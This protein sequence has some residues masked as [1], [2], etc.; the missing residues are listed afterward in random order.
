MRNF[1]I[2]IAALFSTS[3][4]AN[5]VSV[6]VDFDKSGITPVILEGARHKEG[7]VP[8]TLDDKVRIASVTKLY[9]ALGVMRLVEQGKLDLDRDVSDYLGWPLRNPAFPDK[10]ISLRLLLSHQS[11]VSDAADYL[12]PV[13]QTI[14]GKMADPKAWD[15][16][17]APGS[18]WFHYTN[19]NFP[20]VASVMERATGERFD[21]LMDRIVMKPLKLTACFNW[22]M[23]TDKDAAMAVT[24]Y[25]STGEV[26][27]DEL[28]GKIPSCPGVASADGRCDLS[29][30][31]LGWNGAIFSPQGGLRVS[32]KD[33]AKTGQMML[34]R[35][36]GFL[37]PK[38]FNALVTPAWR[39]DGGNGL[40]ENGLADDGFFCA[41]ALAVQTIG[42]GGKG[43]KDDGFGDGRVRLGHAG[44]AYGLKSGLWV[45]VKSG[46]GTAF[47]TTAVP[48][49]EP[50]GTSSFYAIEEAILK[51]P[52]NRSGK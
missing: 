23:C 44:E 49:N 30:Y 48:E 4:A 32:A 16:K 11:S 43:C 20:I 18:G 40:G 50:R 8:V 36:R 12:I 26:A 29:Q 9:V 6:R 17:H 46:K 31:Q 39:F 52:S 15:L 22:A 24:L 42:L 25:R 13:D 7:G 2:L 35:G 37:T 5:A 28:N 10:P 41:Y 19:L 14:R 27:R 33:L 21:R 3:A 45:D 34:R 51:R 38:S 1:L 47:F